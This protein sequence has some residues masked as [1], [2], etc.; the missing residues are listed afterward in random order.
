M[1]YAVIRTGNK[2]YRVAEGDILSVELLNEVEAG[3]SFKFEDVLLVGDG[4]KVTVG[5]P[6]VKGASVTAE[7]VEAEMKAPKV[8]AYKFRRR[9]G[10]HR[11][12][13]HRQRLTKVK[14]TSIKG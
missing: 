6:V 13:G 11:T 2:Q 5:Q 7:V 3:K 4:A 8:L 12:V 9:E 1:S 14:I 10:Y